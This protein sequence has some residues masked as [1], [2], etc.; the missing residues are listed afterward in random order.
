MRNLLGNDLPS[1][2]P[3]EKELVK[4]SL[5]FIAINHYTVFYVSDC[6]HSSSSCSPTE[7]NKASGFLSTSPYKDGVPIGE[8]VN[9]ATIFPFHN[10][11][12]IIWFT[13]SSSFS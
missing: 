5:D 3:T 12:E 8:K 7:A 10:F 9:T 13:I 1:F 6:L 11:S 4:G 2:T